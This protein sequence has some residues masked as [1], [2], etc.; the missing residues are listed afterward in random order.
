[1]KVLIIDDNKG[2][3]TLNGTDLM[4]I[5]DITKEDLKS[6]ISLIMSEQN[7]EF[8]ELKDE[9]GNIINEI[10]NPAENIIYENILNKSKTLLN[11]KNDIISSI[12]SEYEDLI[13]KYNLDE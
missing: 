9:A 4:T 6:L 5:K 2:K 7:I 8:D 3:Y 10:V 11:S 13:A 1:M 12:N